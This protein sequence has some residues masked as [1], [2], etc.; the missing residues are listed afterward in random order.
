MNVSQGIAITGLQ[1]MVNDPVSGLSALTTGMTGLTS[2][3]ATIQENVSDLLNDTANISRSL[4]EV[5]ADHILS[6]VEKPQAILDLQALRDEKAGLEAQAVAYGITTEL[7][8]YLS[9]LAALEA[10]LATLTTPVMWNDTS[11]ITRLAL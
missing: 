2:K 7:T 9:A 8:A 3:V 11:D 4:D 1:G 10:Y 5:N 6:Q